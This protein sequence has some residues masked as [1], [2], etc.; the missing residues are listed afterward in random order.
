VIAFMSESTGPTPIAARI[1][2]AGA[3][4]PT[5]RPARPVDLHAA[6]RRRGYDFSGPTRFDKLFTGI[7]VERPAFIGNGQRGWEQLTPKDTFDADYGRLLDRFYGKGVTSPGGFVT[8]GREAV[9]VVAA[10]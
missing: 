9:R 10:A 3:D 1:Y 6:R 4:G 7:A 2:Y 8:G 5:A